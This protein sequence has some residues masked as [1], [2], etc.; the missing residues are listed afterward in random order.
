MAKRMARKKK[1]CMVAYTVYPFDARVRREA[2][3]L[4]VTG[5]FDVTV[6]C[7]KASTRARIYTTDAV[8]VRELNVEKYSGNSRLLYIYSYFRFLIKAFARC[9]LIFV[10]H[11]IDI[12]HVHNMPNIL[13]L[14]GILPKLF[15]RPVILDM[16]DSL[17]DTFA[18]KFAGAKNLVFRALCLEEKLSARMSD[19]IICVNEVHKE[20]V[21]QRGIPAGKMSVVMNVPDHRHF[22]ISSE[23]RER[24]KQ[25]G[26]FCLVYHGTIEERLGIGIAVEAVSAVRNRIPGLELHLWGGRDYRHSLREQSRKLGSSDIIHFHAAVPVDQ[27][28]PALADMDVGVIPYS[29]TTATELALPVKMMEYIAL[30]IPVVVARLRAVE[31]YFSD[32]MVNFFEPDNAESMAEAILKVYHDRSRRRTQAYKAR[33]FLA[34]YGW[35]K[36]SLDFIRFY[37]S[38]RTRRSYW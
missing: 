5:G 7:L 22:G 21:M 6:V 31:Y 12:M 2:E 20:V 15:G 23:R 13:V 3:T 24:P 4:A 36:Q 37:H 1:V 16:H 33:E 38:I 14:T 17:P 30:G 32:D 9:C 34:H 26:R 25:N 8:V 35:Q 27:L 28:A 19:R 18:A 10:N 11:G 29:K